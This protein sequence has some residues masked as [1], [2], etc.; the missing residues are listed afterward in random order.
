MKLIAEYIWT[1]SDTEFRSKTKIIN[2]SR[3][4][5]ITTFPVWNYDGSSTGQADVDKSEIILEP[6]SYYEYSNNYYLVFCDMLKDG[7]Y[8][9]HRQTT[10]NQFKDGDNEPLFGL[11]QE[12]YVIDKNT[13]LPINTRKNVG[14][15]TD[16]IEIIGQGKQYCGVEYINHM[17]DNFMNDVLHKLIDMNINV[18]GMN[19]EVAP[20]QCEFQ[21]CAKGIKACDQLMVLRYLLIKIGK[22]YNYKIDFSPKPYSNMSGSGCHINFSTK[23][24]RNENGIEN[25]YNM[26]EKMSKVGATD[27]LSYYGYNNSKRLTGLNETC[28]YDVFTFGVGSRDTSIRI[29]TNVNDNKCG[30]LEDRRPGAN[31]DPYKACLYLYNFSL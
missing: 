27:H 1:D 4:I 20:G 26:I 16:T 30:Y 11:E 24:M 3:H 12:F 23:Q 9:T 5:D 22:N 6:H 2:K 31:I 25:I 8:L 14:V 7:K 28:S 19:Y 18:T 15:F 29:P 21:I 17:L 10:L 13:N